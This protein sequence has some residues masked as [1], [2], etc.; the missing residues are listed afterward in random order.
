MIIF[1]NVI[2][3]N[4]LKETIFWK[5]GKEMA[6]SYEG[7]WNILNERGISKTEFRK[8]IN[9][10]TVTLAKMSKNEPVSMSVIETICLTFQCEI[11]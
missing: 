6:I 1:Q 2:C 4:K 11:E 10:S 9:I 5:E 3:Y 8:L 7:L